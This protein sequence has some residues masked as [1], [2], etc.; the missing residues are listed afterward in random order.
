MDGESKGVYRGN[1]GVF[2]SQTIS[3]KTGLSLYSYSFFIDSYKAPKLF[4]SVFNSNR[5]I[6]ANG[7]A[8]CSL[9]LIMVFFSHYG[10]AQSKDVEVTK[11]PL[12]EREK[13]NDARGVEAPLEAEEVFTYVEQ[14]PQFPGG[15]GKMEEFIK[16]HV[17]YP[18]E[19][20]TNGVEGKVYTSFVVEKNGSL[21]GIT[22]TKG[23]GSGCDEE[24]KRVVKLMPTWEPGKMNNQTVRVRMM[25][26][27]YFSKGK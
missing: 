20:D 12:K 24:C 17:H 7:W 1:K 8:L 2:C 25:I 23:I 19:A 9:F 4:G 21:S 3:P 13:P 16:Q 10:K 18:Q 14:M 6:R 11:T 26:P 22:I 5:M 15:K 27:I